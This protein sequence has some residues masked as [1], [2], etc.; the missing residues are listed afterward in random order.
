M[1]SKESFKESK[2]RKDTLGVRERRWKRNWNGN[3]EAETAVIRLQMR[4]HQRVS[5]GEKQ[6]IQHPDAHGHSDGTSPSL[7]LPL[8]RDRFR[9]ERMI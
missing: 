5:P 7:Y 3:A 9:R 1:K 2:P 4:P 6:H 8:A